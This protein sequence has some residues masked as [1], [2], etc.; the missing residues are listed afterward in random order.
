MKAQI[1]AW[2]KDRQQLY[3]ILPLD[4][5]L[6]LEF[7]PTHICNFCCNYCIQ[8]SEKAYAG[9]K[10]FK[11]E[12][13]SW[14]LFEL[15]VAQLSDF[16]G[17]IKMV[18]CAGMGEPLAHPRI[19]D[20]VRLF[21][22]SGKVKKVQI[23]TNASLLTHELAQQLLDAGLDQLKVSLQGI[24]TQMYQKIARSNV[25]WEVVYDHI[26]YFSEIKGACK[27]SV[28][29]GDTALRAGEDEKFH[30]LFG[31]I[32]DAVGIEHIY[33]MWNVNGVNVSDNLKTSDRTVWGLEPREIRVCRQRFTTFDILPDGTFCLGGCHRRFGFEKSIRESPVAQQWNSPGANKARFDMLTKGRQSD[34]LCRICEG[35]S[36]NWHPEDLLEGHEE[37]ILARMRERGM[38]GEE[39]DIA[40]GSKDEIPS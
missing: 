30:R 25:P 5:P 20:M 15:L 10:P 27:L 26:R 11:R 29:I 4:T 32:C 22:N 21:K 14:E 33:N 23:I 24:D 12:H 34:S 28:K 17:E 1:G 40:D 2:E 13:M 19:V 35:G 6:L 37:E 7:H 16:P 39:D 18:S 9:G 8:S 36:Q 31:D 38:I 3:D